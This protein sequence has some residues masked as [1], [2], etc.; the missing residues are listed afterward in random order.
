MRVL[1][2]QTDFGDRRRG[3]LIRDAA[4]QAAIEEAGQAHFCTAAEV[5]ETFFA[6]DAPPARRRGA[7]DA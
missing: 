4:D 1:V 7:H 5:D 3:D 6:E 2:V